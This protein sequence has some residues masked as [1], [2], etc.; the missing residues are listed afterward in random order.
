MRSVRILGPG[1]F[2]VD[3]VDH[4]DLDDTDALVRVEA[5]GIC[6]SDL[7]YIDAGTTG[8]GRPVGGPAALGH[9]SAGT[10]VAVGSSVEGISVGDRVAVIRSTGP[11]GPRSVTAG[12]RVPFP[13]S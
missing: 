6:G 8:F 11:S 13:R 5:C 12:P 1:R 2:S 7:A 3:E 10:V 4:P 9:E